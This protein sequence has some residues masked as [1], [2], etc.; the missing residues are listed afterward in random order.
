M[1]SAIWMA[2]STSTSGG[3]F[4]PDN[5]LFKLPPLAYSMTKQNFGDFMQTPFILTIFLCFNVQKSF[6]SCSTF[7]SVRAWSS[8]VFERANLT[9]TNS[10]PKNAR[11]TLPN[12]P[13]PMTSF[14]SN[15]S[16]SIR[17]GSTSFRMVSSVVTKFA[18]N[19]PTRS[20]PILPT[21]SIQLYL[22][23]LDLHL[24]SFYM[25]SICNFNSIHLHS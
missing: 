4:L 3:I 23:G 25:K 24:F 20:S 13:T 10:F 18:G 19:I 15:S 17:M 5:T 6:A 8:S 21:I 22:H 16:K 1:P 7:C 2:Q 9:A 14:N 11:W 12:P